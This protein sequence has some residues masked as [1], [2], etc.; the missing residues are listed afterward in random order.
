MVG[1]DGGGS[2]K[3]YPL[4]GKKP[5]KTFEEVYHKA[6]RKRLIQVIRGER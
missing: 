6:R 4:E 3:P 2:G 1:V 5:I